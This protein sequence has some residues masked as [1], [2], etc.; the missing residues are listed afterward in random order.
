VFSLPMTVFILFIPHAEE[1]H[2]AIH[3]TGF[4]SRRV[5]TCRAYREAGPGRTRL[6]RVNAMSASYG[7]GIRDHVDCGI[8]TVHL[9][10]MLRESPSGLPTL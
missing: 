2:P 6:D 7:N 1:C 3:A 10:C 8:S 5:L 9:N 4:E